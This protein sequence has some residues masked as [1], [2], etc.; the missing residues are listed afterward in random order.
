[1]NR[2]GT[3]AGREAAT[4]DIA[5]RCSQRQRT[6]KIA[7]ARKGAGPNVESLLETEAR[8]VISTL[9]GR[10]CER[11]AVDGRLRAV[12]AHGAAL[13]IR[14]EAGVG[15]TALLDYAA[16]QAAG[17]RVIRTRAVE[18]ETELPYAGLHLLCAS[19]PDRLEGLKS[20]QRDAVETA[21]GL[22]TGPQLDRFQVG[23]G[24][25]AL[26]SNVAKTHPLLCIVD[27]AQWLDRSTAQ[28]LAF[29]ARRLKTEPI[30]LL[31]AARDSVRLGD[32]HDL[33][34]I[35]VGRLSH[36]DARTLL[37]S[38]IP[39]RVDESV[40]ER[41]IAETRGNPLT[42]IELLRGVSPAEFAGGFGV[43]SAQQVPGRF[44]DDL[45]DRTRHLPSA[46]RRLLLTA[47]AEPIG[48]PTLHWRAAAL[49]GTPTEAA[50][51]LESQGLLSLNPRVIFNSPV[52]R[53]A[54]YGAASKEERRDVH[55][56]LA[57]ATDPVS[58]PDRRAWHLAQAAEGPEEDVAEEMERCAAR[59][60]DRA[61][62][63]AAAAFLEKAAMLTLD[64]ELRA[65]R[66]LAAAAAK[67]QAGDPDAA[68]RL[69]AAAE[70]GPLNESRR[71]RLEQQRA[72]IDFALRRGKDASQ[73]LLKAARLQGREPGFAR[74]AYLEA[75]AAAIFAGR[76]GDSGPADVA[77][78][79]RMAPPALRPRRPVDLLLDG[80]AVRFIEGYAAAVGP[81]TQALEAL[82]RGGNDSGVAGWVPLAGQV[83]A[84]LWDDQAWHALTT[85]EVQRARDA[86]ALTVLPYALSQRAIM[87]LHC[88]DVTAAAELGDEAHA[89][90]IATGCLPL[91]DASLVL[92][93]V[94]GEED[95]ALEIFDKA[96]QDA[97]DRGE[98]I[99]ISMASY[100]SAVL[101]NGLGR[102]D[103][104][105]AAAQDAGE[106]DELGIFG[107]SLV[108]LIEAAVRSDERGKAALALERLAERTRR[109]GTDWALGIE[110]RSRALISDDES[111]ESL[112]RE[113]IER[114]GR[115]RVKI[116]LA[117]AQLVYGEWLRRQRRRIDAREP[118]RAARELFTT[119]GAQAFADRA[120]REYL[121]TAHTSRSRVV[122]TPCEL[123]SQEAQIALLAHEGL[124]NA[125]IGARLFLSP[126]TVEWHLN[127]VYAKLEITSRRELH[128]VLVNIGDVA[129]RPETKLAPF[130]PPQS[131]V[132]SHAAEPP[133]DASAG[134]IL[135]ANER[136]LQSPLARIRP[137]GS[138]RLVALPRPT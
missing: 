115:S 46:S 118:L 42:V 77:A 98:G 26:L 65:E 55:R 12:R 121:A 114:L 86:G 35:V 44:E 33:P 111:A 72:R 128:R 107:W 126:R 62:L 63:A 127:K 112:Y 117:R 136:H 40:A 79:T 97:C 27:D 4:R 113:A 15:K 29:V 37:A 41:I 13:V 91:A 95:R 21:V 7:P 125:E 1:V 17:F 85:V 138:A 108:E 66:T 116:H 135:R 31:F 52:L 8:S 60:H 73:Q 50:R 5:G 96:R 10:E 89:I 67:H 49:L 2:A 45:L 71:G 39:G 92:A 130:A 76:L 32:L 81:L 59:A 69:L 54:I 137:I 87:D 133:W 104:A 14:G 106:L 103:K 48:E 23:L 132:Q 93:A 22:R 90:S 120:H 74:T 99:T 58:D 105:L 82:R 88:G 70:M 43:T 3:L 124:R 34:E 80:L 131:S 38:L 24:T 47:A 61:G 51:T 53:A 30:V 78:A 129:T 122:D 6:T 100:S 134:G 119:M 18:S 68:L 11:C 110:A 9:I 19:V 28:V 123:T 64:S 36:A 102:Y 75:L 20:L 83:A 101:Y 57:T 56:A 25:L 84:D 16:G 109:S 94:R